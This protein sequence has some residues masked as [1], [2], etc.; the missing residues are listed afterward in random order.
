MN[1]EV[2][3][4]AKFA[5]P[6]ADAASA[7]LLAKQRKISEK[8]AARRRNLKVVLRFV[9]SIGSFIRLASPLRNSAASAGRSLES[10]PNSLL[11]SDEDG[12][13]I[14]GNA[15]PCRVCDGPPAMTGPL[16]VERLLARVDEGRPSN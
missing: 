15:S 8:Q 2:G 14:R 9:L 11:L 1:L 3:S 5:A 13:L 16:Q 6:V 4:G 7:W 12:D 10:V